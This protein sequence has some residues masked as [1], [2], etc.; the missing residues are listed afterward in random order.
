MAFKDSISGPR[1][2]TEWVGW[3][4]RLASGRSINAVG[5]RPVQ[6]G[7]LLTSNTGGLVG[8]WCS[9]PV[10]VGT[11]IVPLP[12]HL[13]QC[14]YYGIRS[15]HNIAKATESCAQGLRLLIQTQL[16]SPR[17]IS[18]LLNVGPFFPIKGQHLHLNQSLPKGNSRDKD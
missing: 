14:I 13:K 16:R 11:K 7:V 12:H 3:R 18:D 10:K 15:S 5:M 9:V 6:Q 8:P 1:P 4:L 2:A 17:A